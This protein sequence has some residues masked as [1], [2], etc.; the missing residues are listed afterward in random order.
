MY[1]LLIIL[2]GFVETNQRIFNRND[3]V[4]LI[5]IKPSTVYW[6]PQSSIKRTTFLVVLRIRIVFD[7][8]KSSLPWIR[9]LFIFKQHIT[10]LWAIGTL[11]SPP[12]CS[13]KSPVDDFRRGLPSTKS[14]SLPPLL[15]HQ[16]PTLFLSRVLS[17]AKVRSSTCFQVNQWFQRRFKGAEIDWRLLL[18][19]T[20]ACGRETGYRIVLW[21][22][23][24]CLE[25]GNLYLSQ[26]AKLCL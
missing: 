9:H 6:D 16:W 23:L 8:T 11:F 26:I 20:C 25:L 24:D 1:M 15:Q 3:R 5:E 7:T 2:E 10:I 14:D 17:T 19:V 18:R 13:F 22:G 4:T 21:I 12:K